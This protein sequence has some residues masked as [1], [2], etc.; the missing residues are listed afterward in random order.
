MSVTRVT[1]TGLWIIS[2]FVQGLILCC[3][4]AGCLFVTLLCSSDSS[5]GS[6]YLALF[7]ILCYL[8]FLLSDCQSEP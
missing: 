7:Q 8:Y 4:L 2:D 5:L 1:D 3:Y 6:I